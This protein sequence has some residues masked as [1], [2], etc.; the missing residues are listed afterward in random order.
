MYLA[1]PINDY[2]RP[3][4]ELAPGRARITMPVRRSSFHAA[5]A[6]H[7]SVYGE[8]TGANRRLDAT[9]TLSVAGEV[10]ARGRGRFARGGDRLSQLEVY[11]R[12]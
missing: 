4:I 7:G 2:F 8:V 5:G 9:A 6:L 12:D 1:A 10:V 11:R 3:S